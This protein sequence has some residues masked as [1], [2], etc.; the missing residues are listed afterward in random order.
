MQHR[1]GDP[2]VKAGEVVQVQVGER[3]RITVPCQVRQLLD[4]A[5]IPLIGPGLLAVGEQRPL[6]LG[7]QQRPEPPQVD[8]PWPGRRPFACAPVTEPLLVIDG[9]ENLQPLLLKAM[10]PVPGQPRP[11]GTA[12]VLVAGRVP[13]AQAERGGG[14]V[15]AD[16]DPAGAVSGEGLLEGK[17]V[18]EPGL[19][20]RLLLRRR[21]TGSGAAG[22]A[23]AGYEPL[24]G[25]DT[26]GR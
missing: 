17:P 6:D 16:R 25:L 24:A 5:E 18:T 20:S 8:L 23:A 21:G 10:R 7:P 3:P 14:Q 9:E 15:R 19:V 11:A 4:P 2:G 12:R 13:G 22:R 1:L 26:P